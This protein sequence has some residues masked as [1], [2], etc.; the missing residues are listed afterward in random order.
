M[1]KEVAGK[2]GMYVVAQRHVTGTETRNLLPDLLRDGIA[3]ERP[4][5]QG[6]QHQQLEG[7]LQGC[8][9][10]FLGRHEAPGV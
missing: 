6:V 3:V 4:R 8:R 9:A 10:A 7:A 5:G 2:K 1:K